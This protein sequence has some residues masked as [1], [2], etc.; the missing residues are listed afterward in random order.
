MRITLRG[1]GP[2]V[3]STTHDTSPDLFSD[4]SSIEPERP[5]R[6][7]D[8][9]IAIFCTL[10][11]EA[12]ILD[13]L[14][15][16]Y[17]DDDG[18]PYDKAPGDP[19]YYRNG[20]I[21]R[22]NVVLVYMPEFG[23]VNASAS[24]A[25]CRNSYPNIK[26]AI[27]AGI[28]G[29]VPFGPGNDEIVLGDVVL[30]TGIVR[31]YGGRQ[32]PKTLLTKD[33]LLD[34]TKQTHGET[35]ALLEK[36]KGIRGRNKLQSKIVSYLGVLQD[37]SELR[38]KYPG[39]TKDRLFN[40]EYRHISDGASCEECGCSSSEQVPR[41]RLGDKEPLPAVHF[42]LIASIEV[43]MKSGEDR[44]IVAQGEGGIL[45]FKF[46][47][48]G[49]WDSLPCVVI[50]GACDYADSHKTKVWQRYAAASAAACTKALI[51]SW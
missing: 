18:P 28:C 30:S 48:A 29:A 13:A 1:E 36:L 46:G 42:G 39:T 10:E 26:L 14:F 12:D 17:W 24:A 44:D 31:G 34:S 23:E 2:W 49:V 38:A 47:A 43:V 6:R 32:L 22:R 9:E 16:N 37:N 51:G 11:L 4:L 19:N 25:H 35:H 45:G 50:A 5:T 3:A 7:L 20:S 15:D 33:G 40:A 8:F 41:R 21:G 27:F